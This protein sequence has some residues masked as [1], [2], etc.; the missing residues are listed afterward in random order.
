MDFL[1]ELYDKETGKRLSG[2]D[3]QTRIT[4]LDEDS[5]GVIGFEVTNL[6]VSKNAE[7]LDITLKRTKGSDGKI[8]CNL[9]TEKLNKEEESEMNAKSNI[10]FSPLKDYPVVFDS[11]EISKTVQITLLNSDGVDGEKTAPADEEEEITEKMFKI[12]LSKPGS[13]NFKISSKNVCIVTILQESDA[14]AALVREKVLL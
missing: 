11:G 2:D 14:D 5:P 1:V 9:N 8:S 3:T 13:E 4:I 6:S 7:T 10:D 12:I